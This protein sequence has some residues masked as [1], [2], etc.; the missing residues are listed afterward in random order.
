MRKWL[1]F[2]DPQVRSPNQPRSISDDVKRLV[3]RPDTKGDRDSF[4]RPSVGS[5]S[6]AVQQ[7]IA[8]RFEAREIALRPRG[9]ETRFPG[10]LIRCHQLNLLFPK[11]GLIP[12]SRD[13]KRSLDNHD[14]EVA[15]FLVDCN[16]YARL[17]S[18]RVT[19]DLHRCKSLDLLDEHA[20]RCA[21]LCRDSECALDD[22][23][24]QFAAG[25]HAHGVAGGQ[26]DGVDAFHSIQFNSIQFDSNLK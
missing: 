24:E 18:G 14:T 16:V 1:G 11:P 15:A 8:E 17:H 9:G 2:A 7:D 26:T 23:D 5:V 25:L 3:Q 6:T 20:Q 4:R 13:R 19:G 22:D 21:L 12:I 10:E